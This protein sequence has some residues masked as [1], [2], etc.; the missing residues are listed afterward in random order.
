MSDTVVCWANSNGG[1]GRKGGLGG[2]QHV[3]YM[4]LAADRAIAHGPVD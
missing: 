1:A 2:N 3:A 4:Q